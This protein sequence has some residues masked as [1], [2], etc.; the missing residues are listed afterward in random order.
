MEVPRGK[1]DEETKIARLY[2]V[3]IVQSTISEACGI[4]GSLVRKK[5]SVLIN[6]R[7]NMLQTANNMSIIFSKE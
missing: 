3:E 4:L 7:V 6:S 1:E 2:L 5:C